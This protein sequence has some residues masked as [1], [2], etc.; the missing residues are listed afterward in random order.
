MSVVTAAAP[1]E[2]F[3]FKPVAQV[4]KPAPTFAPSAASV[5]LAAVSIA[6]AP[7]TLPVPF[8]SSIAAASA[9]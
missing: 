8:V 3:P 4:D 6:A 5:D 9:I 1:A 7:S 2:F